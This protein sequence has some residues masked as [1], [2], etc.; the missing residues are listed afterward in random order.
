MLDQYPIAIVSTGRCGSTLLSQLLRKH[1]DVLSLSEFWPNRINLPELFS[2]TPLSGADY[3]NLLSVPMAG[4]IYRIALDGKI[5]QVP[6]RSLH[7]RNYMRRIALPSLVDDYDN[8]FREVEQFV[9]TRGCA[10]PAEHV[11]GMFGFIKERLGK[12]VWVERT[13]ASI[14]YLPLWR[15]MWPDIRIV[16]VYRDGRDVALSMS[17]HHAFR[18]M[19]MRA[20]ANP[21][22]SWLNIRPLPPEHLDVDAFY[23]REIPLSAF[24]KLWNRMVCE[25]LEHLRH[26]PVEQ[27]FWL[28]YEDLLAR[29]EQTLT[30]LL[31]FVDPS[32]DGTRWVRECATNLRLPRNDWR[33]LDPAT[34]CELQNVCQNGLQ[35]LGYAEGTA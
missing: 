1:D 24:G 29:P 22:S 13:G 19:V 6:K 31:A 25:G 4:D 32:L 34:Q 12:Q 14:E 20:E 2:S 35:L 17:K 28:R 16:H 3:W 11:K 33:T 7:E 9:T 10:T 27:Q 30:E 21:E 8:L 5:S 15:S 26:I 23:A 18:L